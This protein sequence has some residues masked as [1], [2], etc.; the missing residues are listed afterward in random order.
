MESLDHAA[1]QMQ[2]GGNGWCHKFSKHFWC[3][4]GKTTSLSLDTSTLFQA[5]MY[6]IPSKPLLGFHLLLLLGV[7]NA[8][9]PPHPTWKDYE[10]VHA[11]RRRLNI[12]YNYQTKHLPAEYCRYLNETACQQEDERQGEFRANRRKLRADRRL[13]NPSIGKHEILVLLGYFPENVSL[14]TNNIVPSQEYIST[15]YNGPGNTTINPVGSLHDWMVYNSVSQYDATFN[16]QPWKALQN[17]AAYYAKNVSAKLT[18]IEV[19]Q[20][21]IPL[22]NEMDSAGFD[23]SP[24][25]ANGDGSLDGLVLLYA[26]YPAEYGNVDCA[27]PPAQRIWSQGVSACPGCWTSKDGKYSLG[28]YCVTGSFTFGAHSTNCTTPLVM[29]LPQHG[30]HNK[31]PS[32]L[33]IPA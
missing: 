10:S 11:M 21:F 33:D 5:T 14:I 17:S 22:L 28:G 27:P 26:G 4:R 8:L 25:D 18:S 23:W 32:L 31:T 19:A 29:G 1:K 9:A 6:R 13:A 20:I 3:K 16:V 24:F 30:K 2:K 7:A 15:L 12:T